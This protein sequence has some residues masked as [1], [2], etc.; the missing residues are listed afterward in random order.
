MAWNSAQADGRGVGDANIRNQTNKKK[1]KKKR[2]QSYSARG[3][4]SSESE[5]AMGSSLT[6]ASALALDA[7][8]GMASGGGKNRQRTF[9]LCRGLLLAWFPRSAKQMPQT[10]TRSRWL[11]GGLPTTQVKGRGG[12]TSQLLASGVVAAVTKQTAE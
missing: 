7:V 9:G 8:G 4:S 3:T 2:P 6:V 5:S 1:K 12:I 11:G 10:V